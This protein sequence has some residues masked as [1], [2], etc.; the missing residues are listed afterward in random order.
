[1]ISLLGDPAFSEGSE[2]WVLNVSSCLFYLKKTLEI[3]LPK[4]GDQCM[5]QTHDMKMDCI[6]K[7]KLKI[8]NPI[9]LCQRKIM[10]GKWLYYLISFYYYIVIFNYFQLYE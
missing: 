8:R 3:L 10:G 6:Q 4:E 7:P 5:S 2:F 9:V 1:M